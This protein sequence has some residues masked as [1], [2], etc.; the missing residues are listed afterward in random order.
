MRIGVIIAAAGRST[1]FGDGDKLSQ[2]LGGRAVLLRTVEAFT[3]RDEV[4]AIV[5][6]GPPDDI[7]G[8]RSRFGPALG[9]NGARIVEGGRTERWE[10][11]RKAIAEL[12]DDITHIAVHDGARPCIGNE[13]LDR[14]FAAARVAPAVVP[15]V[16]VRDT[17]KRVGSEQVSAAEDDGIAD[18]ILGDVGKSSTSGR[19]V[20]E[21][22]PRDNLFAVQTPQVFDAALLRRAYASV[23]LE[24]TTDD[25]SVVERLGEPVLVVEGDPR[26][27]KITS[28]DDLALVRAIMSVAP[29]PDR[30]A[31]LRF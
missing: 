26:N 10:S 15:G 19:H 3:K 9:F 1:R 2:D 7:E 21:T 31:H 22:V 27:I 13:L 30:P 14:V 5:V 16:A 12:P 20:V 17:L 18:M 11:I 4:A 8:F 23:A 29:P 6:A 25:A 28:A 24:G